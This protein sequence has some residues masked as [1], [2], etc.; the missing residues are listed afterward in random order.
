LL[1][2]S[3]LKEEKAKDPALWLELTEGIMAGSTPATVI[4]SW[5]N[6]SLF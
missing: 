3:P 1:S 5:Y 2:L 4:I 6:A